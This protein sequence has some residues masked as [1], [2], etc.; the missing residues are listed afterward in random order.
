MNNVSSFFNCEEGGRVREIMK[1][2]ECRE[3]NQNGSNTLE[4]KTAM[5]S[6]RSNGEKKQ[7]N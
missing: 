7:K 1:Y 4:D 3:G 5:F 6:Y 2:E